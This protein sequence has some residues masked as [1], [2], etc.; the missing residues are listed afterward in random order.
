MFN[1]MS[2]FILIVMMMVIVIAIVIAIIIIMFIV[3]ELWVKTPGKK[4]RLFLQVKTRGK[5]YV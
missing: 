2:M 4:Y 3:M 1:P 5:N